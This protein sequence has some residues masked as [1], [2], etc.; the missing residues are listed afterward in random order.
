MV[1][2]LKH[3]VIIDCLPALYLLNKKAAPFSRLIIKRLYI[4]FFFNPKTKVSWSMIWLRTFF[5]EEQHKDEFLQSRFIYNELVVMIFSEVSYLFIY[6]FFY[7]LMTSIAIRVAPALRKSRAKCLCKNLKE[8]IRF[9]LWIYRIVQ[10]RKNVLTRK[11]KLVKNRNVLESAGG[12]ERL[13]DCAD[14]LLS[15]HL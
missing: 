12:S 2:W 7:L 14:S 11:H 10:R 1:K 3:C 8:F 9:V 4:Y 13:E 6:L 15:H 5:H